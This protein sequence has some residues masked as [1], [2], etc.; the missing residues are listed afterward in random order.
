MAEVYWLM[1]GLLME[2]YRRIYYNYELD[3][4]GIEAI[5]IDSSSLIDLALKWGGV[6]SANYEGLSDTFIAIAGLMAESQLPADEVRKRVGEYVCEVLGR[7][8]GISPN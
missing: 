5:D 8:P 2:E 4:R 6:R 1:V 3:R 7:G